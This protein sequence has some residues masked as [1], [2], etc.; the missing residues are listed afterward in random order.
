[1]LQSQKF[2]RTD[3]AENPKW[4]ALFVY[5][6]GLF[7]FKTCTLP[8]LEKIIENPDVN[9]AN[10]AA[11]IIDLFDVAL[12]FTNVTTL[13]DIQEKIQKEI[14]QINYAVSMYPFKPYLIDEINISISADVLFFGAAKAI[15]K[16]LNNDELVINYF[17]DEFENFTNKQQQYI[18]TLVRSSGTQCTF[19]L[20]IRSHAYKSEVLE[21]DKV[22]EPNKIGSEID[23]VVLDDWLKKDDKQY[24]QFIIKII[25]KKEG[26]MDDFSKYYENLKK[27]FKLPKND[28]ELNS[29]KAFQSLKKKLELL[30]SRTIQNIIDNL[31]IKGN[32]NRTDKFALL[33]KINIYLLYK[34]CLS[35][36][37]KSI[38]E[39]SLSIKKNCIDYITGKDEN[40]YPKILKKQTDNLMAQLYK[41]NK[42]SNNPLYFGLDQLIKISNYNPRH[43]INFMGFLHSNADYYDENILNGYSVKIQSLA[44]E[45][46]LSW[47]E[48]DYYK[49]GEYGDRQRVFSDR[50]CRYLQAIRLSPKPRDA[51]VVKFYISNELY[52]IFKEQLKMLCS[53]SILIAEDDRLGKQASSLK[54]EKAFKINFLYSKKYTLPCV[55]RGTVEFKE[56]DLQAIFGDSEDNYEKLLKSQQLKLMRNIDKQMGMFE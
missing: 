8:L 39:I 32:I 7:A 18:Q 31:S 10:L 12:I 56:K 27:L 33:E 50:I 47:F 23:K 44:L 36:K 20:G 16:F 54:Q 4:R 40:I 25:Q 29:E 26:N 43:F 11:D 52:E 21:T 3:D 6:F 51:S 41:E 35:D 28:K 14:K 37:K 17:I 34:R 49:S 53:N 24:K 30:N 45:Q 55:S 19:R 48:D 22:G 1:M 15:K 13:K 42:K 38:N 5:Y 9:E 46:T 2:S